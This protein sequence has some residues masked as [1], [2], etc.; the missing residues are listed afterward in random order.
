MFKPFNIFNVKLS[1]INDIIL[2][3]DE[4]ILIDDYYLP[5]LEAKGKPRVFGNNVDLNQI[6]KAIENR[7]YLSI[8]YKDRNGGTGHRLIE[9]YVLGRGYNY[10][11]KILH[12]NTYYLRAFV[13][14][15]SSKDETTVN[16]FL[17]TRSVSVSDKRNRWRLFRVDGIEEMFN[18]KKKFSQYRKQ[19]NPNDS[20]MGSIITSLNH[21][22]FPKGENQKINF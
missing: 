22:E 8:Y 3:K 10:G 9:P 17:K 4:S 11:D 14:M 20:Q 6:S 2:S 5:L 7:E 1:N 18:L 13:I 21:N 12:P 19:Y 15:D 16:R